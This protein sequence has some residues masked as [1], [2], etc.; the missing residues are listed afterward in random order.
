MATLIYYILNL[1]IYL[2][3]RISNLGRTITR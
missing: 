2:I 1:Y 3:R